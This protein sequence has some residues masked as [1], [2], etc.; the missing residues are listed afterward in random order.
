MSSISSR[1]AFVSIF[2]EKLAL[3]LIFFPSER[4]PSVNTYPKTRANAR[5]FRYSGSGEFVN[6][7]SPTFNIHGSFVLIYEYTGVCCE[8]NNLSPHFNFFASC[9]LPSQRILWLSVTVRIVPSINV[10]SKH[11]FLPFGRN[12]IC[13][14]TVKPF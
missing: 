9:H 8:I 14:S 7:N 10:I 6:T 4:E 11:F 2:N 1:N 5:D 12:S 13:F 3:P